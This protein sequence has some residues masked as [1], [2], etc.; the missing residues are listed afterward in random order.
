M[1]LIL[2]YDLFVV[3]FDQQL[4]KK[5]RFPTQNMRCFLISL[6]DDTKHDLEDFLQ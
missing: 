5:E 1:C 6:Q 2:E 4:F 3:T